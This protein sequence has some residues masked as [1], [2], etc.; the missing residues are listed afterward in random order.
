MTVALFMDDGQPIGH[1]RV[2]TVFWGSKEP[3][4]GNGSS[5]TVPTALILMGDWCVP[6]RCTT[7]MRNENRGAYDGQSQQLRRF[8]AIILTKKDLPR[9]FFRLTER[10]LM[11]DTFSASA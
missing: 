7:T 9:E 2:P 6:D 5:R 11:G 1:D 4:A 8:Q 10:G 3:G